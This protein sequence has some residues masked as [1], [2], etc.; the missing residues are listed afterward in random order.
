LLGDRCGGFSDA[1]DRTPD[2]LAKERSALEQLP[3]VRKQWSEAFREY[4]NRLNADADAEKDKQLAALLDRMRRLKDEI[5]RC[6]LIQA[7]FEPQ[8]QAHGFVWLFQ[9]KAPAE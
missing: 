6:Q 4:R 8:V 2:E 5:A 3:Q 9:R 7:E 1:P